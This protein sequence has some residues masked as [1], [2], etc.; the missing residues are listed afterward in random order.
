M[1]QRDLRVLNESKDEAVNV[2]I[3]FDYQEKVRLWMKTIF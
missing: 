2:Q 3:N 1:G